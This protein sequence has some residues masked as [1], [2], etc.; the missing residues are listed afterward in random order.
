[1][2]AARENFSERYDEAT[3]SSSPSIPPLYY[4][5]LCAGAPDCFAPPPGI[6]GYARVGDGAGFTPA[7]AF[8]HG[9]CRPFLIP[10]NSNSRT[11]NR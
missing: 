2:G 8:S 7:F 1:M 10:P 6:N 3:S 9:R 5:L 4:Y 11:L